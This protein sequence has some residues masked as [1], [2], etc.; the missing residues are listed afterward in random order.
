[1]TLL[2][3][4]VTAADDSVLLLSLS[5]VAS[6]PPN[7]PT[8]LSIQGTIADAAPLGALRARLADSSRFVAWNASNSSPLPASYATP[9]SE[10]GAVQI[11]AR[12]QSL[13]APAI[14]RLPASA[15]AGQT[16]VPVLSLLLTHP[17]PAG[18]AAVRCDSVTLR[19]RDLANA[20]VA[21]GFAF[22]RAQLALR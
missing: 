7:L 3:R 19:C 1:V 14:P 10:G 17:G 5:P 22:A 11:E 21:P 8:T 20:P 4:A 13:V 16:L 2:D 15:L 18:V 6:V 9:G 12:A